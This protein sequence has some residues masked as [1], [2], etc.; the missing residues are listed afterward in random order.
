MN[1]L[2]SVIREIVGL[3]V[4]DEFLALATLAVVGATAIVVK[5][6]AIDARVAGVMLL[7]GCLVVLLGGVW[8]TAR[9]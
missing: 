4:D 3:F 9:S 8:R 1:L 7:G 5:G 6:T 2:N